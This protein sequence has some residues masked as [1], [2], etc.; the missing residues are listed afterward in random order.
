MAKRFLSIWCFGLLFLGLYSQQTGLP[1][2]YVYTISGKAAV[3]RG[4]TVIRLGQKSYVYLADTIQLA[5][6]ASLTLF[7]DEFK[8]IEIR[9]SG[10][11]A[12]TELAKRL[13][14]K[15]VAMSEK[16]RNFLWHD[17][18]K[19]EQLKS[20]VS[21]QSIGKAVGGASRGICALEIEPA[22]KLKT[23]DDTLYFR[24][25]AKTGSRGY[26]F[27][28]ADSAQRNLISI[29]IKDTTLVILRQGLL[30]QRSNTYSWHIIPDSDAAGNCN[31]VMVFTV[32]RNDEKDLQVKH[33]VSQVPPD[34]DP[35]VFGLEV[36]MKLASAGWYQD[37]NE[38]YRVAAAAVK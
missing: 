20:L 29:I 12:Y 23:T 8:F 35:F 24:W 27:N 22:D 33:L 6:G 26:R 18:F 17:L 11:Y 21:P 34:P 36:A 37:A 38:W 7:T 2:G 30:T 15:Q 19:P 3:L 4:G 32:L 1:A 28:L 16:V 5:R 14:V 25:R 10:R 31:S 9:Q 13:N